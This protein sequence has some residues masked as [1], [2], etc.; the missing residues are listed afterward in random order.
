MEEI[1]YQPT[2]EERIDI[3]EYECKKLQ[4]YK[5]VEKE[6]LEQWQIDY[7]IYWPKNEHKRLREI[8][9]IKRGILEWKK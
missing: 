5:L 8:E 1:T 6:K 3:L 2:M 9:L 7:L 4:G